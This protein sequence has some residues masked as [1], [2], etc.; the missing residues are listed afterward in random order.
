MLAEIKLDTTKQKLTDTVSRDISNICDV[1]FDLSGIN[2]IILFCHAKFL[3]SIYFFFCYFYTKCF[4][5][6][7]EMLCTFR[8]Y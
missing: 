5:D 1:I 8:V 6:L 2:N 4:G 7:F 3:L